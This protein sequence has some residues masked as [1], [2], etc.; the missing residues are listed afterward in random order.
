ML[1]EM[2]KATLE[3]NL[4]L[5][6]QEAVYGISDKKTFVVNEVPASDVLVLDDGQPHLH[7][8]QV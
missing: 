4:A 1:S 3:Q 6:C 2:P 8:F 7:V 5:N